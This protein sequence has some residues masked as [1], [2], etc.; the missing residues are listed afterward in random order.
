[1]ATRR[2][3]RRKN[4]RVVCA[5]AARPQ[6]TSRALAARPA[7]PAPFPVADV[8]ERL[9]DDLV[10]LALARGDKEAG[11]TPEETTRA[12]EA[13]VTR[14]RASLLGHGPR[15]AE[16]NQRITYALASGQGRVLQTAERACVSARPYARRA[17]RYLVALVVGGMGEPLALVRAASYALNQ[18]LA[19]MLI[20]L[21]FAADPK[22]GIAASQTRTLKDGSKLTHSFATIGELVKLANATTTTAR[23]ELLTALDLQERG[24]AGRAPSAPSFDD[25]AVAARVAAREVEMKERERAWLAKL[26]AEPEPDSSE[27]GDDD[28]DEHDH[29]HDAGHPNVSASRLVGPTPTPQSLEALNRAPRPGQ[30]DARPVPTALVTAPKAPV[31]AWLLPEL[32]P[33][34]AKFVNLEPL[35]PIMRVHG[36]CGI[37]GTLQANG[38]FG[39]DEARIVGAVQKWRALAM[40]T[41]VLPTNEGTAP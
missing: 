14:A 12:I 24:I 30:H 3:V 15:G 28:D 31:L 19:D 40:A 41:G 10:A 33:W 37:V 35:V 13:R 1:M 17:A 26:A 4:Q 16:L 38:A 9:A 18:A 27:S 11:R 8:C 20:D 25:P 7:T 6:R 5:T 22:A 2:H 34:S 32:H 23:L 39:R 36:V 29:E 21:A